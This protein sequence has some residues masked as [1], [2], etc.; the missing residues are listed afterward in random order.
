MI[1]VSRYNKKNQTDAKS[2]A[3][4]LEMLNMKITL[5]KE[6]TKNIKSRIAFLI[7]LSLALFFVQ[8]YVWSCTAFNL[9]GNGYNLF[10]KNYEWPCEN[11]ML[12]INKRGLSKVAMRASNNEDVLQGQP[13]RWIA[14]YGSIT[15]NQYGRELPTG[16]MNEEGLVVENMSLPSTSYPRPDS[17]PFIHRSQWIQYQLDNHKTVAQIIGSDT[18]LRIFPTHKS[19]MG[20]HYLVSDI[21]GDCAV[22]EFLDG[23]MVVYSGSLLRLKALANDTYEDSLKIWEENRKISY[24]NRFNRTIQHMEEFKYQTQDGSINSVFHILNSV[25]QGD[26]TKWSIVYDIK[27]SK[28]FYRTRSN[29]DIRYLDLNK[30]DFSCRTPVQNL[31]INGV[32]KGNIT[33]QFNLYSFD[34]NK[35]LIMDSFMRTYKEAF[36]DFGFQ[37]LLEKIAKYPD[38]IKCQ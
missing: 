12:F 29:P 33:D 20:Y 8:P 22:I 37:Q 21:S 14:R 2:C 9:V 3:G 19:G 35:N 30:L 25:S 27:N 10:G 23:K 13:V 32:N 18:E 17:R 15:F 6:N 28:I 5:S 31:D 26:Y 38:T 24:Y 16:G 34:T 36:H 4:D 11:G 1:N 7:A